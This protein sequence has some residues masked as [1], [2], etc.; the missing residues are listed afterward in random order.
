V[1]F[2]TGVS[3]V[4]E[5]E[6]DEEYLQW[7]RSMSAKDGRLIRGARERARAA[8]LNH[9]PNAETLSH[10]L[11]SGVCDRFPTLKFVSVES[12]FGYLPFLLE[13]CD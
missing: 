11:M 4:P 3:A 10:L 13:S 1:N 2:H 5:I 6:A 8:S 7:K 12:G 9:V